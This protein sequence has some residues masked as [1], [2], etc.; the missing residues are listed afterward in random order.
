MGGVFSVPSMPELCGC[1]SIDGW[2]DDSAI[3]GYAIQAGV[4]DCR[5]APSFPSNKFV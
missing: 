5:T 4:V 2:M 3:V 1:A